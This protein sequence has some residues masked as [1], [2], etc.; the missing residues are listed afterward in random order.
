MVNDGMNTVNPIEVDTT[1]IGPTGASEKVRKRNKTSMV[2]DEFDIYTDA[3]EKE[4][5]LCHY[6]KKSFVGESNQGTSH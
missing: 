2:W 6:C 4:K 3:N 5:A 1:S